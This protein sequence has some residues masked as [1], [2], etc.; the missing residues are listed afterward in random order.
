MNLLNYFI[1][2]NPPKQEFYDDP[3]ECEFCFRPITWEDTIVVFEGKNMHE[4]CAKLYK[5]EDE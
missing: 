2:E 5:E 3:I 1:P 4:N